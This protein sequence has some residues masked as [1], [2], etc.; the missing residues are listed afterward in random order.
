MN[1]PA[2]ASF[3][4]R[5]GERAQ[6]ELAINVRPK[7]VNHISLASDRKEEE[8]RLAIKNLYEPA[9][10]AGERARGICDTATFD[11]VLSRLIRRASYDAY[12]ERGPH[13]FSEVVRLPVQT[14]LTWSNVE[15][16]D[17]S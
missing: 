5:V 13:E 15:I 4:Q 3:A 7:A 14:D 17:S 11:L 1:C 16:V 6:R 10:D 8:L 9:G 12:D 2:I